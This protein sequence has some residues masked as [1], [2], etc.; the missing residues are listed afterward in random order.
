MNKYIHK[1]NKVSSHSFSLILPKEIIAK[2][3]WRERQK[4]IITDKGQ[5]KL[6]IRDWRRM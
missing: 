1:L 2:Y 4:L 6:E 5:G 3:G